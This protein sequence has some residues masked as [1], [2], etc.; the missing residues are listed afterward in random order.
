MSELDPV[1]EGKVRWFNAK[2][3]WGYIIRPNDDDIFVHFKDIMVV[4][5]ISFRRLYKG[6]DVRYRVR[7]D[8]K[9]EYAVNVFPSRPW[10]HYN[11]AKRKSQN[12]EN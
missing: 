11:E 2:K 9:G 12:L 6:Q 4:D 8:E 7:V 5:T 10:F 3:G 1:H